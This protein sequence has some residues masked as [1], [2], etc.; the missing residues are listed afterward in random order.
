[1]NKLQ[2]EQEQWSLQEQLLKAGDPGNFSF[3][4]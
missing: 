3:A 1:M 2:F 4:D